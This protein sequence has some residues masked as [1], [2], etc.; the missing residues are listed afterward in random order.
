MT[1]HNTAVISPNAK[2]SK[3]V[4]IGPWSVIG[5]NVKI[6]KNTEI[7][8]NVVIDGWTSIG[9]NNKISPGAVIGTAPQDVKYEDARTYVKIG[10]GNIIREYV[11]IN[12][13]TEPETETLVGNNNFLMAYTHI[14]HNCKVGNNVIMV[15]YTALSGHT[16]LEDRCVLSGMVGI[17]QGAR[18]GRLAIVG[19]LSKVVKDI[20]PFARADG[21]PIR[22][23]GLNTI[24]LTRNNIPAPVIEKLK[25]AYKILF[26]SGMNTSQ[27]IK[28]IE[29]EVPLID[30]IQYLI[31]FIRTSDRGICK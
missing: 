26:R 29:E 6:G 25:K 15:N 13:A 10:N 22:I 28:K 1:I 11:T 14:A 24:G 4:K 30:E 27:A 9:E 23:Y 31:N 7:G 20:P 12:R 2:I 21:H 17:H 18:V 16:V 19:G 3:G 8:S 5:D